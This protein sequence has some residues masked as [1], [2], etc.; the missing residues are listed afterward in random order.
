MTQT[1]FFEWLGAPM[2]NIR[3]SWGA[4]RTDG[5]VFLRIWRDERR[6]FEGKTFMRVSKHAHFA[7]DQANLGYQERIEHIKLIRQGARC[8]LVMCEAN[9]EKL[10]I[11]EIKDFN[12]DDIFLAGRHV[13]IG[14]DSWLE[15][16]ARV[17]APSVRV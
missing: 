7:D 3:W 13:E 16:A 4:V 5:V 17:P 12:S 11:R 9:Q 14:G 2:V 1:Q 10:P 6:S 15:L 8:Y